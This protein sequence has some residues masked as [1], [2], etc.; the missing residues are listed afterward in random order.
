MYFSVAK[1]FFQT[2]MVSSVFFLPVSSPFCPV[3]GNNVPFMSTIAEA[4]EDAR[5]VAHLQKNNISDAIKVCHRFMCLYPICVA[6]RTIR[7]A[8]WLEVIFLTANCSFDASR[9]FDSNSLVGC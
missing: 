6:Y 2:L 1:Q 9:G 3:G 7:S 8:S 5:S 4:K